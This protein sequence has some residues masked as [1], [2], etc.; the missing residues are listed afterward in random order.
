MNSHHSVRSARTD[1]PAGDDERLQPYLHYVTRAQAS[2][3]AAKAEALPH[4]MRIHLE[5]ARQWTALAEKAAFVA[6]CRSSRDE[7]DKG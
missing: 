7:G 1:A 2:I 6:R 4:R 5:A 3:D